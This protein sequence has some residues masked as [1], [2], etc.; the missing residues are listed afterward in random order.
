MPKFSCK[1]MG[2]NCEWH[3]EADDLDKLLEEIKKH[4]SEA[5]G[6]TEFTPDLVEKVKSVI[7]D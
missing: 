5:H 7:K 6:I 1:D 3:A 2:M 4:A